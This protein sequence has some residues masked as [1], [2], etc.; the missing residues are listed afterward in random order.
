MKRFL[1]CVVIATVT[2]VN[3]VCAFAQTEIHWWHSMQG[4]LGVW[5]NDLAEQFN[6]SQNEYRIIPTY[7]GQYDQSMAAGIAA[8]RAGQAPDILQVYEVGTASMFYARGVTKPVALVMQEA[9][10]PFHPE[11]YIPAV[12]GYYTAPNGEMLSFPFNSST[13]VLFY[14]KDAFIRA[15]LDPEKPPLT[16]SDV[17]VY[18]QALK[19]AGNTCPMTISWM[20]WTQLESFSAWHNIPYATRNNG[21]DGLDARL[22]FN[23]PLHVR[24]FENL[25]QMAQDGLFVYKGRASQASPTFVSGECAMFMGSSSSY[26]AI[27]KDAQFAFGESTL[28]Y[29]DD[30]PGAPQN[31]VIGGASLWVMSGKPQAHYQ[32][33]ARFFS[34]LSDPQ[35]QANNHMRTGYLP[36]TMEAFRITE[37]SNFYSEN[38]GTDVAVNQMIRQA[39]SNSRGIRLG[40]MLQIR[41]IIDEETEQIWTGQKTAQQALDSAV[42]RGNELLS[43]FESANK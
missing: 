15:G 5:I 41:A 8:Y 4:S 9:G 11:S 2:A 36:V 7:K 31:T 21:M 12:S 23:S 18:A 13:T 19:D 33:V 43:R 40:N 29:Y 32:G 26:A 38:P 42:Q 20:G 3:S 30:V 25:S 39:T 27:E 35:V 6:E 28:P 16:W 24:H 22:M 34:F 14:N 1:A 37:D 17:R 10:V